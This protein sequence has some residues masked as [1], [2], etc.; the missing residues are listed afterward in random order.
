MSISTLVHIFEIIFYV[1]AWIE[2]GSN[3]KLSLTDDQF[4]CLLIV[5]TMNHLSCEINDEIEK[6]NP[7]LL[8]F[9][10]CR[11]NGSV[12]HPLP[13]THIVQDQNNILEGERK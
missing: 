9:C 13:H 7:R 3:N 8:L 10:G 12:T 11:V 2:L 4:V 6:K 5:Q 1:V